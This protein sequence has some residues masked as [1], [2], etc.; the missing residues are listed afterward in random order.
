MSNVTYYRDWN[1][2]LVTNQTTYS[3]GSGTVTN[4]GTYC[5]LTPSAASGQDT[6]TW[7]NSIPQITDFDAT[8]KAYFPTGCG[9]DQKLYFLYRTTYLG[10]VDNSEAY[11]LGLTTSYAKLGYGSNSASGSWHALAQIALP[12]TLAYDTWH[13]VRVVATGNS[14]TLYVNGTFINT[15][16]DS[17]YLNS[18]SL[19]FMVTAT[20]TTSYLGVDDLSVV[21]SALAYAAPSTSLASGTYTTAKSVTLSSS[22][23]G[24]IYYTLDGSTPTTASLVYSAPL[25]ISSTTALK[26]I[27][28]V[29]SAYIQ[30]S[31]LTDVSTYTYT[32]I[33]SV[34]APVFTTGA[35]GALILSCTEP[36]AEILYTFSSVPPTVANAIPYL[37]TVYSRTTSYTVTAIA[38]LDGTYS[39]TSSRYVLVRSIAPNFGPLSL[40]LSKHYLATPVTNATLVGYL[41]DGPKVTVSG[42]GG[43]MPLGPSFG[44]KVSDGSIFQLTPQKQLASA[45]HRTGTLTFKLGNTAPSINVTNKAQSINVNQTV[46]DTSPLSLRKAT[47][48]SY[49][50]KTTEATHDVDSTI[51]ASLGAP[52]STATYRIYGGVNTAS[53]VTWVTVT[54][55]VFI[56]DTQPIVFTLADVDKDP[57]TYYLFDNLSLIKTDTVSSNQTISVPYTNTSTGTHSFSLKL[58]DDAQAETDSTGPTLTVYPQAD[59]PTASVATGTYLAST[60]VTLASDQPGAVL[61]YTLDG[62][63]PTTASS[64]YSVALTITKSCTLKAISSVPNYKIS[65]A[66]S[67]AYTIKTETPTVSVPSGTYGSVQTVSLTCPTAGSSIAYT[68]DGT[69]PTVSFNPTIAPTTTSQLWRAACVGLDGSLY[70]AVYGGYIYKSLDAGLTWAPLSTLQLNW[71]TAT[72][73][74]DGSLYFGTYGD[75][76]YKSTDAGTTWTAI[77]SEGTRNWNTSCLGNDGSLYFGIANGY[78]HKSD[79]T[80]S[81]WSTLTVASAKQWQTCCTDKAGNVYFAAS[82]DSIYQ[83]KDT[84]NSWAAIAA[85]GTANWSTSTV[86]TEGSIYFG[87][88]GGSLYKSTDTGTTWNPLSSAGTANWST[89]TVGTDGAL[90]FGATGT[91]SLK[92]STDNGS[93]WSDLAIAGSTGNWDL[94]FVGNDGSVYFADTGSSLGGY[95]YR[96]PFGTWQISKGIRY[97]SALTVSSSST[98]KAIGIVSG[99]TQSDVVSAEYTLKTNAPVAVPVA[100]TYNRYITVTLASATTG[101]TIYYTLDGTDPTTS[102]T[103]YSAGFKLT[104]PTTVKALATYSNWNTSDITTAVYDVETPQVPVFSVAAGT[105]STIQSVE[106]TCPT[107][108]VAIYYTIDGTD[109][110]PDTV[111]YPSSILYTS[112][113]A[114]ATSVT[115]KAVAVAGGDAR[116][117][118]VSSAYVLK[119]A[120]PVFS[121]ATGTYTDGFDTSIATTTPNASIYYTIDGSTPTKDN[122]LYSAPLTMTS[123]ITLKAIAIISGWTS[124]DVT[125]V[126]YTFVPKVAAAPTFTP[127]IGTYTEAIAVSIVSSTPNKI[128]RYTLDGTNPTSTSPIYLG[129]IN[130]AQTTTIKAYVT[131]PG[132]T[133]STI[134]EATYT[135]NIPTPIPE[136]HVVPV[137][138][139]LYVYDF[140]MGLR[141]VSSFLTSN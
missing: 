9:A 105:Y 112:A 85:L 81:T 108:G 114:V 121:K 96:V 133:D 87:A 42:G 132:Y 11:A 19:G 113:I 109:P 21:T 72:T 116:S 106:L 7:L 140:K 131:A 43:E 39:S 41:P 29:T 104:E 118:I 47:K 54:E 40:Q 14:H 134:S 51:T 13:T 17:T 128:I 15:W 45:K 16:T 23:A 24:T 137:Y 49:T 20:S 3:T 34:P 32:F 94:S 84:G 98:L 107:L 91:A 88:V 12:S 124:S 67:V 135:I 46:A 103:V 136:E 122:Y 62:T 95:V 33:L 141:E 26:A 126:V 83:T 4:P 127:I 120:T 74:A 6:W 18:G 28:A 97:T 65:N 117:D 59:T 115:I 78:I 130:L 50:W 1:D 38:Y 77:T 93:T 110:S 22:N 44:M 100:G 80:G 60:S 73:G 70:A 8:Y 64:V 56:N 10:N 71:S 58:I 37:G 82:N 2:G 55:N 125:T 139:Y 35:G 30:G 66:L 76:I 36:S 27:Q 90:Y 63:I 5:K 99:Q 79:S 138:S 123:T 111:T 75:Y 53:T 102:S 92:K 101:A 89:S 48:Y 61:Y 129:T 68:T 31:V 119:V 25:A 57:I 69:D 52:S 86:G